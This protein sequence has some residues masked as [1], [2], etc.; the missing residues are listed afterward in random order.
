[1]EPAGPP[2]WAGRG[3]RLWVV[4][5]HLVVFAPWTL[6][7][8]VREAGDL[9]AVL[10]CSAVSSVALFVYFAALFNSG[11]K[12][13]K[14]G[15]SYVVKTPAFSLWNPASS[16]SCPASAERRIVGCIPG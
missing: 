9:A 2:H 14:I 12:R 10:G 11:R 5:A 7:S 8:M 1:M 13:P 6:V 3:I 16:S 4:G 15:R